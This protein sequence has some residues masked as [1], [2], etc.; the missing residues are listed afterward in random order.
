MLSRKFLFSVYRKLS[1]YFVVT[2]CNHN[3]PYVRQ[4]QAELRNE[5]RH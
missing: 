2:I 1:E 5:I 4:K 3:F